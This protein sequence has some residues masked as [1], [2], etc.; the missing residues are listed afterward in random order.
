MCTV[1]SRKQKGFVFFGYHAKGYIVNG[2]ISLDD[3][4]L[5]KIPSTFGIPKHSNVP[6]TGTR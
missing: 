6:F 5:H 2:G 1:F 3:E 4:I